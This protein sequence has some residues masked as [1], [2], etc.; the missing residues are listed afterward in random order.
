[1]TSKSKSLLKQIFTL[2]YITELEN[3]MPSEMGS[4]KKNK[5]KQIEKSSIENQ[6]EQLEEEFEN[7]SKSPPNKRSNLRS[8]NEQKEQTITDDIAGQSLDYVVIQ[9]NGLIK[10]L[11]AMMKSF[12]EE[13]KA[14]KEKIESLETEVCQLKNQITNLEYE[15]CRNKVRVSGLKVHENAKNNTEKS[16]ETKQVVE[17]LLTTMGCHKN[18]FSDVSRIPKG[19]NPKNTKPPSVMISF[20]N[21]GDKKE[22]YEKLANLK[23]NTKYKI[24]VHQEFPRS[25]KSRLQ[26]LQKLEFEKRNLGFKTSIR[27]QESN[28]ALFIKKKGQTYTKLEI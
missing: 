22:F 25:L 11:F 14:E 1:M 7:K 28:L 3:R 26:E 2:P 23:D 13:I 8:D 21:K 15:N 19:A 18:I 9:N 4:K 5:R 17:N 12:I 10:S 16:Y 20:F 27:F 24:Q 6:I